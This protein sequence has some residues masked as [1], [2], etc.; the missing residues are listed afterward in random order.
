MKSSRLNEQRT[1]F[2]RK[3]VEIWNSLTIE[4][5]QLSHEYNFKTN[6]HDILFQI[7]SV[8]ND[9]KILPNSLGK[10]IMK[11]RYLMFVF[12]DSSSL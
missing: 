1:S 2:S 5:R 4:T 7:L 6:V 8:E 12:I 11:S 10:K 3:G 9:Y